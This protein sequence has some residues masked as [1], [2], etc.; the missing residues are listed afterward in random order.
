MS[1]EV[2]RKRINWLCLLWVHAWQ[3]IFI[4]DSGSPA[5]FKCSRCGAQDVEP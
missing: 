3:C 1:D 2:K 5:V 4:A